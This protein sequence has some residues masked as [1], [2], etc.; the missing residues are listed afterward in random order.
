M[1]LADAFTQSDLHCIQVTVFTFFISFQR[2]Q[3][4]FPRFGIKEASV[5]VEDLSPRAT[6]RVDSHRIN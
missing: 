5:T 6:S 4:I 3:C 2:I 1:H